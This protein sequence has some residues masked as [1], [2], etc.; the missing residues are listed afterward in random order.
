MANIIT[1]VETPLPIQ[2]KARPGTQGVGCRPIPECPRGPI[3]GFGMD[4]SKRYYHSNEEIDKLSYTPSQ[5][6]FGDIVIY[7]QSRGGLV[8][9][10]D[11]H[12]SVTDIHKNMRDSRNFVASRGHL[13]NSTTRGGTADPGFRAGWQKR[14]FEAA[15][16][17][18][19]DPTFQLALF[20]NTDKQYY[21]KISKM[22]N[23]N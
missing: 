5:V 20:E 6:G 17:C 8:G 19:Q 10:G 9:T 11:A 1:E 21:R 22:R 23:L 15:S 4:D 7:N 13:E 2:I 12:K 3:T 14:P 16:F 18:H